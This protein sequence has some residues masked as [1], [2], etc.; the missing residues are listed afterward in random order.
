[1]CIYIY[2]RIYNGYIMDI[3]IY[4]D[5]YLDMCIYI[6]IWDIPFYI[7]YNNPLTGMHHHG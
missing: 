3:Y 2:V 7:W 5:I 6:Y 1:M 4:M